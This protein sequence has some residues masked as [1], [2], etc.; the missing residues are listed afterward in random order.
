MG[1][2][3]SVRNIEGEGECVCLR[4]KKRDTHTRKGNFSV[5]EN[6]VCG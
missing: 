1:E 4:E 3:V 2:R 6:D 5:K